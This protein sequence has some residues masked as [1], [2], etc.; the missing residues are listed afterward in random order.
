MKHKYRYEYFNS[1]ENI[2][3]LF[4]FEQI[5]IIV[6]RSEVFYKPW[7]QSFTAYLI[8]NKIIYNI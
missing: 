4:T 5:L 6:L 1:F 3:Y 2:R 7:K 8:Y